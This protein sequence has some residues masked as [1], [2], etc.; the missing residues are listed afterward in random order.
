MSEISDRYARLAS[1][2]AEKIAAVPDDS[3]DNPSPCEG[4]TAR[5]VVGHVIS[6]QG[7]FLGFVGRELGD[8]PSADHDPLGAWRAASAVVHADLE[9]PE[10][11]ATEFTGFTGTSTF[12][13]AVNRFL[14]FDLV[15]HNWDL[16]RA[17]GQDERIDAED[18]ERVRQQAEEFGDAMRAP[19]AFGSAIEPPEGADSQQKLLAFLGRTP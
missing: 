19:Q 16:S 10:R 1:A 15:V 8:I 17:T 11:A 6:T 18:I 9:N 2:F 7:M 14:C 4:W 13:A 12:E 5:D 3:W